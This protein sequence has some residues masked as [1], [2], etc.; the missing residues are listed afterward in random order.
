MSPLT[1][2]RG[3]HCAKSSGGGRAPERIDD[4]AVGVDGAGS[5]SGHAELQHTSPDVCKQTPSPGGILAR[6]TYGQRLEAALELAKKERAELSAEL[7]ISVSAIGQV[8]NTPGSQLKAHNSSRAARFLRV[9]HHWLATGEGEPRP[10]SLLSPMAEDLARRFDSTPLSLRD[11]VYAQIVG[12]IELAARLDQP[13]KARPD[14]SPKP[15]PS[16][17]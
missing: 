6:M 14:L 5:V 8:I 13:A 11:A 17:H 15:T 16:R 1:D 4:C 12:A 10:P 7:G 3:L 2:G 9:D